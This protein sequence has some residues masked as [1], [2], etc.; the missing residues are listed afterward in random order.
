MIRVCAIAAMDEARVIG[1]HGELPWRIPE[2]LKRFAALTRGHTVVMGRKTFESLPPAHRPLKDRKNIVVTRGAA[3][4][5]GSAGV[6]VW[7]D[8]QAGLERCR[9]GHEA[10]PSDTV[11]IIGGGEVYKA[12]LGEW[13]E[14]YLTL[15]S[16]R[17]TGD[18]FLPEFE[19]D[20][21]LVERDDRDGYAFLRYVRRR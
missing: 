2:D 10:L 16:G 3:G 8:L 1:A 11:W 5:A 13:D 17:H 19:G 7:S 15:V 18:A 14:V 20:F 21:D 9:A 6:T 12:T 4:F